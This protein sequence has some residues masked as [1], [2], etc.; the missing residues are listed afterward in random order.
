MAALWNLPVILICEN[1][2]YAA[3]TPVSDSTCVPDI[4][5]RAAAYGMPGEVVDGSDVMA[6]HA[7]AVKAVERAR[8]GEGPSLLE[9]KTFRYEGHCMAIHDYR[10][11]PPGEEEAWRRK[12]PIVSLERKLLEAKQVTPEEVEEI[13]RRVQDKL[14]EAEEFARQSDWPDPAAFKREHSRGNWECVS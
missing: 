11:R 10:L 13:H 7:A 1:N 5:V 8:A 2:H 12:D 9:C 4:A 6:V 3:T 14:A